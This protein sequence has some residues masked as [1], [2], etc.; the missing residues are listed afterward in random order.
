MFKNPPS[1]VPFFQAW[2]GP[3]S[4]T[5]A[6]FYLDIQALTSSQA[7][8]TSLLALFAGYVVAEV[9]RKETWLAWRSGWQEGE[10]SI[11]RVLTKLVGLFTLMILLAFCYFSFPE[12][13]RDFYAPWWG[14][15]VTYGPW[16]AGA[17]IPY[18]V[19]TDRLMKNPNDGLYHW[20]RWMLRKP[21]A[22]RSQVR[23]FLFAW[24]VKA[25]FLPLMFVFAHGNRVA[26]P[27]LYQANSIQCIAGM[28][29]YLYLL[30]VCIGIVGYLS[31]LRLFSWHIHSTD[32]TLAGWVCALLCYPPFQSI[33]FISY[34]HYE[35]GVDWMS[36]LADWP[37]L[38]VAWGLVILFL[39]AI[40]VWSTIAFGPRFSNLT[41]RGIV[42]N[43]PYRW[44]KHPAYLSKNLSWWFIGLP[45]IPGG[46]GRGILV[47]TFLLILVNL[48][49]YWR[50][51]TEERHLS[52]DPAYRAYAA[53]IA[54][55]GLFARFSSNFH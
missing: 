14:M 2:A 46:D 20:A 52:R 48:I 29:A 49:Y 34:L 3:L 42:T 45:L 41:H 6:I 43:G 31:T 16:L 22:E 18:V 19:L 10:F 8:F 53:W 32:Q 27:D 17:A 30:D 24:L 44:T 36:W 25:F 28:V 33:I 39:T 38:Q 50:A 7:L 11:N 47:C 55:H 51:K 23:E 1:A 15:V 12:Y 35:K 26:L 9:F 5:L 40:Y 37:V 4:L 13:H 21:D 54:K